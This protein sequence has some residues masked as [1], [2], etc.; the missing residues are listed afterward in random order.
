MNRDFSGMYAAIDATKDHNLI[1]FDI[2]SDESDLA[3]H[4]ET[5]RTSA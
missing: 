2:S 5:S 4:E 1:S 3:D